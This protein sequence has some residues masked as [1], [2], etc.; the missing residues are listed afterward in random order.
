MEQA[1][2]DNL[3]DVLKELIQGI[4]QTANRREEIAVENAPDTI[5]QVQ[6][7]GERELAIRQ[8]ESDFNKL[9]NVRLAL[10]RFEDGTYGTCLSCDREI[11]IKR[12]KAVPW[13][14]HCV[15]CQEAAERASQEP[16]EDVYPPFRLKET[17]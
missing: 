12:L 3:R 17:A 2:R 14:S 13:A 6:R 10:E 15:A 4:T 1:E 8:I 5:D 11:N 16:A 7:A 9:Q